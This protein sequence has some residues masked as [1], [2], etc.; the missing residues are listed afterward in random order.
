[1]LKPWQRSSGSVRCKLI[2]RRSPGQGGTEV[3]LNN[4]DEAGTVRRTRLFVVLP[5]DACG[6]LWL[7]G[8]AR[9][10]GGISN[11]GQRPWYEKGPPEGAVYVRLPPLGAWSPSDPGFLPV[12]GIGFTIDDESQLCRCYPRVL[13]STDQNGKS[14]PDRSKLFGS[15]GQRPWYQPLMNP[16][17]GLGPIA[18]SS[19]Y[20]GRRRRCPSRRTTHNRSGVWPRYWR[21]RT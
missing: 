14:T 8:S 17:C 6:L 13:P 15:H 5:A 9:R 12:T 7:A 1:L 18:L 16:G 3:S 21:C 20:T 11:H 4:A 10:P 19:E 2:L